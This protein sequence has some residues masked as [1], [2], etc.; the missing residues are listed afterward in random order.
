[1]EPAE[2][3]IQSSE[4]LGQV[5]AHL[6]ACHR[7][8]LDTEFVGEESYHPHLCLIQIATPEKL[9]LIDPLAL[10]SLEPLWKVIVDPANEV[11]VHAGREEVRLCHLWSG[12]TPANLFDLQI[13]AGLVGYSYPLGHGPLVSQVL[14]KNLPKGETLTE[15][16]TRPLTAAQVRYA[17]D[18]VRYLLAVWERLAGGLDKLG[19]GEWARTEFARLR[20]QS[21][22]TDAG[23]APGTDRWR[24]LRG[25]G[26]LDRQRLAV[27]RELYD[28]REQL[29]AHFNRPPR[30]LVRDDLLVEVARRNPRS[31]RDL[32]HV[33]GLAKRFLD[34]M[35]EAV[36]RGR[37]VPAEDRPH[38]TERDVDPP[39]LTWLVNVMNAVL[40]DFC[41][42]SHLANSLVATSQDMK[43]LVRS[44]MQGRELPG[45]TL[46][47]Q[48]W[49]AEYVLPHLLAV[50]D[51]R[52]DIRIAD[53]RS[54]TPLE[55]RDLPPG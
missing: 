11:V 51:G 4:E 34:D 16:R 13:A 36:E 7:F 10:P 44:R 6:S 14:G 29:A 46:L 43:L 39:Q 27:L 30:T 1:M 54:Q 5:C 55:C 45:D 17:Y 52:R 15:W 33:R 20:D 38:L 2:Q 28:W 19:R 24:K 26:A 3:L 9:L 22:L 50:L 53:V 31:A 8:G 21:T 42:R 18:D 12:Q 40:A 25:A 35:I 47:T 32:Q 41:T 37:N 23:L 48:D 49:R